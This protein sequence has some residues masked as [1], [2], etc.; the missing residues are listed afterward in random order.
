MFSAAPTRGP[1]DRGSSV[2]SAAARRLRR[3]LGEV[4]LSGFLAIAPSS[5]PEW[6]TDATLRP[7]AELAVGEPVPYLHGSGSRYNHSTR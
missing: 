2:T 6:N 7:V 4:F 3:L 1:G 5:V